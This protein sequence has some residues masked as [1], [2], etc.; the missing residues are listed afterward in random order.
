MEPMTIVAIVGSLRQGSFNRQLAEAAAGCCRDKARFTILDYTD[1]PFM[2]QDWEY[3]PPAAVDRVRKAVEAADGVWFFTPEYNHFFPGVLK[4]LL[5]WLSRPGPD[6]RRVLSGKP[7]AVSGVTPGMSGTGVA[8]DHLVTLISL[9]NMNVMNTPRLTIP[10]VLEQVKMGK[11]ELTDS[12]PYL[13]KQADAFLDFIRRH[14][15][16]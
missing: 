11:L 8:Q 2:D 15:D 12:L 6:K 14:R 3:P 7:A 16:D 13:Q 9:L 1:V 4:N 5:D 10:H